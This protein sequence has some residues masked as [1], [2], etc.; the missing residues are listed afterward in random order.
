MNWLEIDI[1][2]ILLGY[3]E[4]D[5]ADECLEL[6]M[7]RINNPKCMTHNSNCIEDE[8]DLK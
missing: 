3:L 8:D 2:N 6:I 1:Y 7:K 4:E 5:K